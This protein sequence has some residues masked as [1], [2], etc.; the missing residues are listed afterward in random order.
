MTSPRTAAVKAARRVARALPPPARRVAK[1][2]ARSAARRLR[3]LPGGSPTPGPVLPTGLP[4][5][6]RALLTEG[7]APGARGGV[8]VICDGRD[9]AAGRPSPTQL[10]SA[11]GLAHRLQAFSFGA[12]VR[13]RDRW[14]DPLPPGTRAVLV[15][16]PGFDPG[17]VPDDVTCVAWA[18][19]DADAWA[20]HPQATLFDLVLAASAVLARRLEPVFGTPVHVVAPAADDLLGPLPVTTAPRQVVPV[21]VDDAA[22]V[23]AGIVPLGVFAVV[24]S[25]RL[26]VTA[27]RVGLPD[28]GL[29]DVPSFRSAR[30]RATVLAGLRR[31]RAGSTQLYADLARR[32]RAEHTWTERARRVAALLTEVPVRPLAHGRRPTVGFFPDFRVTNPYQDMLYLRLVA[33]GVRVAPVRDVLGRPVL[34]DDGRRLDGYLLHLHW[35][36][37]VVQVAADEE[38]ARQRLDRFVAGV[39]DLRAR[40][41]K[42]AWTVH[43]VLPHELTYRDL[44]LQLCRFLAAEADLVHVMGP[45]TFT[46]TEPH[47]P[48]DPARTVEVAHSSYTGVYPELVDRAA[49]RDRLGIGDGEIALLALGGIRPYRGLDQLLDVFDR[50]HAA[51]PRLRLLVAGKP[52]SFDG[53]AQWQQRC[54]SDPRIVSRFQHLPE[55]QLQVWHAAADLAVL[56]YRAILNSGAFK[57][58]QTFGLP[59]V[60]PRDGCLADALDPAYAFGFVPDDPASLEGAVRA[61][62]ALVTNREAAAEAGLAARAEAEAYP[63]SAMADD[64]ATALSAILPPRDVPRRPIG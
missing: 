9:P 58:A 37:A 60:A 6:Y 63:P 64:F 42:L 13:T 49:A 56:P 2:L 10:W 36:S 43:N 46:A 17:T 30:E 44:E 45:A 61:G 18:V 12:C 34:R 3:A 21:V 24:A 27:G 23:A 40:G 25:G 33:D 38:A 7:L 16:A 57:L 59:I 53:L 48:L 14:D 62:V 11:C 1:R 47:F 50:L 4:A 41:G 15:T 19:D 22:A 29:A 5:A 54:E 52:G 28:L 51:D 8:V 55:D 20:R 31:D 32:M 26:P 39:R 35:T